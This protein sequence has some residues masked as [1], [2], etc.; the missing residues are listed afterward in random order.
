MPTSSYEVSRGSVAKTDTKLVCA[1]CEKVLMEVPK[2]EMLFTQVVG[3]CTCSWG[4]CEMS[5]G[6]VHARHLV[7]Q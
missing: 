3:R 6:K 7:H 5:K 2:G 4:C 1:A